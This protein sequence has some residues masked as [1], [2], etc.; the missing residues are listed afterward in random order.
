ML[1]AVDKMEG[2]KIVG[3]RSG[4]SGEMCSR[5]RSG[6]ETGGVHTRYEGISALD[7]ALFNS[8]RAIRH[9]IRR[10]LFS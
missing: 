2:A 8:G 1:E 6:I 7:F 9:E 4:V 10:V 3:R 5:M